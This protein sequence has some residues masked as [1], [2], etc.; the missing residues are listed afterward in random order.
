[1]HH[2]EDTRCRGQR[3]QQDLKQDILVD[4]DEAV[5][6]VIAHN[7]R[8]MHIGSNSHTPA[9]RAAI[10][11][12]EAVLADLEDYVPEM[13]PH[14]AILQ[15]EVTMA[16]FSLGTTTSEPMCIVDIFND[17][18]TIFFG[19]ILCGQ[20]DVS[21]GSGAD[22]DGDYEKDLGCTESTDLGRCSIMLNKDMLT[23]PGSWPLLERVWSTLL[24]EMCVSTFKITPLLLP[25]LTRLLAC[26][27]D[28]SS[29]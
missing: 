16:S 1:M 15:I 24:H 23:A 3:R 5:A 14:Q 8:M 27:T 18:D 25:I 4:I 22:F 26:C 2:P 28:D 6:E 11:R 17:L 7:E 20:V 9:E 12:M 13:N 10:R 19:G 29:A 21:W